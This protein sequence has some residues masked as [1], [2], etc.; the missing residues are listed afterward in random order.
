MADLGSTAGTYYA[1]ALNIDPYTSVP[2]FRTDDTTP[3][4]LDLFGSKQQIQIKVRHGQSKNG[5]EIQN[6]GRQRVKPQ[7]TK[8]EQLQS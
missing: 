3:C 5:M 1:P 4:P 6:F 8:I 7:Y 2:E